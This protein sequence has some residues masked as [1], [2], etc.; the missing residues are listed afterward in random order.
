MAKRF[1]GIEMQGKFTN[2]IVSGV[3]A[4]GDV[5]NKGRLLYD[6]VTEDTYIADNSG[7]WKPTAGVEQGS[8][9]WFYQD[10]APTGWT[11]V[12]ALAQDTVIGVKSSGADTYDTGGTNNL[13]TWTQPNHTHGDGSYAGPSHNHLWYNY[14]TGT[15]VYSYASNGTTLLQMGFQNLIAVTRGPM[16]RVTSAEDQSIEGVDFYTNN[17][18]GG[19]V[20]GTSGGGA[21]VNTWRPR[22]HVGILATKD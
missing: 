1:Y 11:I 17:S 18:G 7:D 3:P 15:I 2:Q 6:D 20:T 10:T 14:S 21:T 9:M 19:A 4:G 22:A 8:V 16:F 5:T 12:A 13:G